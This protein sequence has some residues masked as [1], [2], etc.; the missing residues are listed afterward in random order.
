MSHSR[1]PKTALQGTKKCV[2]NGTLFL[3][4]TK[5]ALQAWLQLGHE[6]NHLPGQHSVC[7]TKKCVAITE[8]ATGY[9]V[10]LEWDT[11][12][13]LVRPPGPDHDRIK[14]FKFFF[15]KNQT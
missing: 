3:Q 13:A 12:S 2:A 7:N 10:G 4:G 11:F 5:T 6:F 15:S 1:I 8:G 14:N 9:W